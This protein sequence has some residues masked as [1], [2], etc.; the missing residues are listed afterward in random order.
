MIIRNIADL[1]E[2]TAH[3]NSLLKQILHPQTVEYDISFSMAYARVEA[4]KKTL[5]HSLTTVEIYYILQGEGVMHID[6]ETKTVR[7][8]NTILIPPNAEQFIENK[9]DVEL[10]FLCVVAP[11][12][13]EENETIF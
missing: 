7:K 2:I 13:Q 12:W 9:Q 5:P 4:H 8:N 6:G 1:K 3:D 10:Q 11:P